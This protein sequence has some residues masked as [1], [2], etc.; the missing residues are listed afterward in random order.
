MATQDIAPEARAW[1]RAVI[2]E[3]VWEADRVSLIL[4]FYVE[5][6]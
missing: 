6:S 3:A 4:T 1:V 5:I 2:R